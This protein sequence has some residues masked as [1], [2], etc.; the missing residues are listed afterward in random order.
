VHVGRICVC[1]VCVC[2]CVCPVRPC[3]CSVSPPPINSFLCVDSFL[4]VNSF[5]CVHIEGS[6][7]CF[8]NRG[9]FPFVS[10][11]FECEYLALS[12]VNF[13]VSYVCI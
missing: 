13:Y 11:S 8:L 5:M 3:V 12:G 4:C 2:V 1:R 10:S 9:R 7:V 6:C